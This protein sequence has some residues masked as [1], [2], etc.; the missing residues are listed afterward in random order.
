MPDTP[1]A[2]QN[3]PVSEPAK[4]EAEVPKKAPTVTNPGKTEVGDFLPSMPSDPKPFVGRGY[5][6]YVQILFLILLFL[7]ICAGVVYKFVM[8]S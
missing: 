3:E 6:S 8:K 7:M 4:P 2:P 1:V 5:A